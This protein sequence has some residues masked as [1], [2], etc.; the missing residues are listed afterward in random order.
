MFIPLSSRFN[1]GWKSTPF[2]CRLSSCPKG[3]KEPA[4]E[5]QSSLPI[6]MHSMSSGTATLP[7]LGNLGKHITTE[8]LHIC[9]LAVFAASLGLVGA[10]KNGRVLLTVYVVVVALL[11]DKAFIKEQPKSFVQSHELF[12]HTHKKFWIQIVNSIIT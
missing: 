11:P 5:S 2:R 12:S 4:K 6:F 10:F 9:V 8:D 3:R 1:H 7:R